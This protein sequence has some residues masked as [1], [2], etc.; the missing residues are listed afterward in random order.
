MAAAPPYVSYSSCAIARIA[1]ADWQYVYSSLQALKAHVQTIRPGDYVAFLAYVPMNEA[2]EA[3]LQAARVTVRDR[4]RVATCVG[5]GPRY[6]HSTGQAYKGGP[7]AGVFIL[8]TC[9]DAE[10]LPVP[11][12]RHS[13]GVVKAAQAIGDFQ[14]LRERGRR[15]LRVHLGS[16]VK[17]GLAL[18]RQAVEA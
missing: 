15:A 11:G 12:R 17:A 6:L 16:D 3:E 7:N 1:A 4:F 13:F 2:H 8:V 5:F 9:D 14:V 10:D 18:L